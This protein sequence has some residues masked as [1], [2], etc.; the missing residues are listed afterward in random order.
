MIV[1]RVCMKVTK[2]PLKRTPIV[3]RM[4]V[5]DSESRA[6][7]AR[8]QCAVGAGSG[9]YGC[10]ATP[11]RPRGYERPGVLLRCRGSALPGSPEA[12]IR[13]NRWSAAS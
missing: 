5:D 2:E 13:Y 4:D 1:V 12:S 7:S 6:A 8:P 9:S 11:V 10:K 3:L